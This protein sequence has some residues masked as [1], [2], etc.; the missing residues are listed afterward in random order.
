MKDFPRLLAAAAVALFFFVGAA[1]AQRTHG[2]AF[3]APGVGGVGVNE[4]LLHY[5]A[6]GELAVPG[7]LGLGAEL[8]VIGSFKNLRD[9][10]ETNTLASLSLYRHFPTP[11]PVDPYVFGGYSKLLRGDT[12]N[13]FNFGLGANLSPWGRLGFKFEFRGHV[14]SGAGDSAQLW[15][16]RFAVIF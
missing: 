10:D 16:G 12:G 3:A 9:I 13:G 15:Q 11:G 2:Y 8:G 14:F 7:R 1:A 5:G 6:G 4:G